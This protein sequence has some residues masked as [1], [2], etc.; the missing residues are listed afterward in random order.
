MAV[1]DNGDNHDFW[2]NFGHQSQSQKCFLVLLV[3]VCVEI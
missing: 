3:K 2:S 1:Y